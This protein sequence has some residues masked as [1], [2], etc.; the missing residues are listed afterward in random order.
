MRHR[1]RPSLDRTVLLPQV[2]HGLRDERRSTGH[3]FGVAD[4]L[5]SRD[6]TVPATGLPFRR[7]II[8]RPLP[9][10]AKYS[11]SALRPS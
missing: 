4:S 9:P 11:L 5:G 2:G 1:S 6:D 3:S 7:L 8:V 10:Q